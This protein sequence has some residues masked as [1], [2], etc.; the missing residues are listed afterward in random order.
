MCRE[1]YTRKHN[2][3]YT[4]VSDLE[5]ITQVLLD[6]PRCSKNTI[7]LLTWRPVKGIN[8]S[9]ADPCFE[10]LYKYTID[11]EKLEKETKKTMAGLNNLLQNYQPF[12]IKAGYSSINIYLHDT[13]YEEVVESQRITLYTLLSNEGG[14]IGICIGVS[15]IQLIDVVVDWVPKFLQK[16]RPTI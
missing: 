5:N 8:C 16:R 12:H 3:C 9:C 1:M 14:I 10:T 7:H 11:S 6:Y 15:I 13:T 4:Y 2:K